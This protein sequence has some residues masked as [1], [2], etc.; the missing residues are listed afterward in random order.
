MSRSRWLVIL[1]LGLSLPAWGQTPDVL[2]RDRVVTEMDGPRLEVHFLDVGQ[3]DASLIRTPGGKN[4]LVDCGPRSA[5]KKIMAYLQELGIR[6]LDG[7]LISHSH[8][9]HAGGLPHLLDRIPVRTILFSGYMHT[10][11]FNLKLLEK[12]KGKDIEVRALKAGDQFELDQEIMVRVL[13]PP[14]E[15]DPAGLNVNDYSVVIRLSYKEVDFLFTGDAEHPSERQ[16]LKTAHELQSEFL[17]VGHHGSNTATGEDFLARVAPLFAVISCGA[18]N[19]FNH[20][21]APALKRLGDQGVTILRTDENGT[22][23]AF[24]NGIKIMIKVK[25]KAWHPV[26]LLINGQLLRAGRLVLFAGELHESTDPGFLA[27]CGA[28]DAGM[29]DCHSWTGLAA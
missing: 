10:T 27:G 18:R 21:H 19:Q 13:H 24:T 23:M 15:W 16:I 26:S 29:G 9:D 11:K 2:K 12:I 28:V 1:V 14:G 17:K 25:G 22:V 3:G 8:M 4:Y 7:V 6:E 20:P 5:G